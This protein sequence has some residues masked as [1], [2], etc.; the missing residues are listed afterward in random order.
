MLETKLVKLLKSFN[1]QDLRQAKDFVY[2][3]FFNKNE[4]VRLLFD[5]VKKHHPNYTISKAKVYSKLF[6]RK[7][8]D[9]LKL[10]HLMSMLYKVLE[11]FLAVRH[12][13]ED[14]KQKNLSLLE[15]L[16]NLK[17][18]SQFKKTEKRVGPAL[19]QNTPAD[20]GNHYYA[21]RYAL[22]KEDFEQIHRERRK[23][24]RLQDVGQH[25]DDFYIINKL[26]NACA[27]LSYQ[28]VY[29]QEYD[30]TLLDTL[31][32]Y[33]EK[34]PPKN[35]LI[36]LYL[37]GLFCIKE[38]ENLKHFVQLKK[39]L[40]SSKDIALDELQQLHAIARNYCIKQ[41]NTGN[42]A[43]FRDLFELYQLGLKDKILLDAEGYMSPA[44]FK[45]ILT[46][47]LKVEAFDWTYQFIKEEMHLLKVA[48][49]ESLYHYG[50]GKLYFQKKE[51]DKVVQALMQVEYTDVFVM[52]DSKTLLLKTF[53]ELDEME[54][55]AALL[56][57]FKQL[58]QRKTILAYHQENYK[59]L[60][61]FTKQMINLPP[62]NKKRREALIQKVKAAKILTEREWLLENL[63]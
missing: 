57:S 15:S 39:L 25:L 44:A 63:E 2:A 59:N 60:V 43:F 20:S 11:D 29:Q 53:Y 27:M 32:Q 48:E 26:K 6:P 10:R 1:K 16:Y 31:L 61:R 42:T 4:N 58:L 13:Y 46:V 30:Y 45:N 38:S 9:D 54:S 52:L 19:K 41:V 36:Q 62:Y 35:K 18:P 14:G 12:F 34:H 24:T 55:L 40:Q 56:H 23:T 49:R 7:K 21:F 22:L 8:Y 5:I 33:L 51:Y 37:A 17:L 47:A 50:L 3:P 28:N